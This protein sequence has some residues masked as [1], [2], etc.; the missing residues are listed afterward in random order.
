MQLIIISLYEF[1]CSIPSGSTQTA[2]HSIINMFKT[3]C[4]FAMHVSMSPMFLH[5]IR[6]PAQ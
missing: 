3:V 4:S 5:N 6:V 1:P 2:C